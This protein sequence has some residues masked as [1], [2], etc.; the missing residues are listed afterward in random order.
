MKTNLKRMSLWLVAIVMVFGLSLNSCSD[1]AELEVPN[2]EFA[3]EGPIEK[4]D[5]STMTGCLLT[6][7]DE[8][9][10]IPLAE[11]PKL[12]ATAA[13]RY[14]TC[15]SVGNQGPNGSCV[16]WGAAYAG[17]TIMTGSS[18]VF[19]PAYVYNQIKI[20]DC[21]SGSYPSRAMS[22]MY[23]Q[24]VCTNSTMPYSS[25][26]CYTQPN[27]YQRQEAANYRISNYSRVSINSTSIRNQVANGR[28]VVVAGRVDNAFMNLGYNRILTSVSGSGGGHCYCVVGYNDQ[29][30]CFL[31]LNSW[32]TS[33]ATNGY[34]WVSY[35]IVNRLWSE[36]YVMY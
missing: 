30:R 7:Q 10:K 1:E 13:Y 5:F 24:G 4:V 36:A 32:G 35:D 8:Y 21:G 18:T 28:P 31:I 16:G 14:L 9:E 11:E 12:K 6:P 20:S 3:V 27:S 17:R 29:Y 15:P 34:G 33:W 22:L 19:S 23:S 2:Q 26:D 25:S